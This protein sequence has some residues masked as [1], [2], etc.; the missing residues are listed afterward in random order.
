MRDALGIQERR[1]QLVISNYTR[2]TRT[3]AAHCDLRY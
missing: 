2:Q 1:K 3:G